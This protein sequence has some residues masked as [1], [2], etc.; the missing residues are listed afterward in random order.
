MISIGQKTYD[1]A[2][3]GGRTT[4]P[5]KYATAYDLV[6]LNTISRTQHYVHTE[7]F[8]SLYPVVG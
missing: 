8:L 3:G 2:K 5:P 1:Q 6:V 4:A 7:K